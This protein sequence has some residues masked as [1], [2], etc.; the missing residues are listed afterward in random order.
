MGAMTFVLLKTPP[1]ETE[2]T[3]AFLID[4]RETI[5]VDPN[6]ALEL[7]DRALLVLKRN[8]ESQKM[9]ES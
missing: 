5:T 1:T 8:L 2:Q 6:M 9:F 4:L 7:V 3:I